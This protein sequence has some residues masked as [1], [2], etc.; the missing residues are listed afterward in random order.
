MILYRCFAWEREADASAPGGALWFP[1][2]RQ[3]DG[4]HDA[5]ERYGCLYLSEEPVA[6]VVERLAPL[7]GTELARGDLTREGRPLALAALSLA[8]EARL[9]DLDDPLV[10]AEEGLRPSLVATRDLRLTRAHAAELH[11]RRPEAA[12][13]RWCSAFE[14]LW[15]NV[16]LFDRAAGLV[17]VEDVR[18]VGL[19]DEAVR[20]AAG[21][22]G[23]PVAA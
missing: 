1:R 22:L 4:R 9:V 7:A 13:I 14:S 11:E 2:A 3:G 23:L 10:L 18:R 15:A 20:E 8:D 6:A 17:G 19:D 16:T 21:F 12:G 5:P